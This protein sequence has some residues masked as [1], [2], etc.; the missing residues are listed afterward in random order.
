MTEKLILSPLQQI[1]WGTIKVLAE[2][3]G[4]LGMRLKDARRI[5]GDSGI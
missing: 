5:P 3:K 4:T 2:C 1:S